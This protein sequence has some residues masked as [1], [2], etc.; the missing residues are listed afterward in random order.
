MRYIR[1]IKLCV[2]VVVLV[3]LSA[4]AQTTSADREAR[5]TPVVRAYERA[6]ESVVNISATAI[7]E[8]QRYG[9]N[10]FGELFPVPMRQNQRSVG[11]GFVIHES[12]YVVTNAHVVSAAAQLSVVLEDGTDYD[13]KVI[14]RDNIRDLAV[15][16][17]EPKAPL[18]PIA[19]GRSDDLMIGEQTIAIGNPVGLHNTLTTGV[20]SALHRELE[21]EGRVVY[22]D[23]IQTDAGIN[24]G[25]SGGPLLNV[26]GELIGINTAIRADAQNIGFA[27][28]VDQLREML[29]E[30]LAVEKQ[31]RST[32]GFRL[33]RADPPAIAEVV[34]NG[35]AAGAGLAVGDVILSVNGD[36]VARAVDFYVKVLD[37]RAGQAVAITVLRDRKPLQVSVT[38]TALPSPD[39]KRLA[40][41]R[42]GL[43]L[44]ELRD[45]VARRFQLRGGGG[46][47]VIG[48]EPRGPADQVGM[49]PGDLI[50]SLG[51]NWI[52]DLEQIG[53]LLSDLRKGD[54]VDV[55]F[56]RERRGRLYDWEGRLYAR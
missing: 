21:V 27:I 28:P 8:V 7:V 6:R 19:I 9:I 55:G 49:V 39:G 11:S 22:R 46:V 47:I 40:L 45:D 44:D 31:N 36:D 50:V 33:D 41:D 56:R 15:I 14:G 53:L 17:F 18:R 24:P 3:E 30:I 26:L 4:Q 2:L 10:F 23:L 48:V 52:T 1:L 43:T 12:G 16:K 13:A 35:P 25:N 37:V 51:S 5:R 38:M 42:L 54:A 20:I 34:G 29:P 32:L